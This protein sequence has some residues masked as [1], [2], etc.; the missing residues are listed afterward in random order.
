MNEAVVAEF[1]CSDDLSGVDSCI[2]SVPNGSNIDTAASGSHSFTVDSIDN[3]GNEASLTHFYD[4][5]S[6]AGAINE[7]VELV[8]TFNLQQGISNSLDA[9]LGNAREALEASNAGQRQDA[10]NKLE[11]FINAVEAQRSEKLTEAQA[12]QLIA[13]AQRIL[14][15]L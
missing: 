5:I 6:L 9:K 2:G 11:A 3:A 7:V 4:V 10:V 12:D 8:T 14:S 13:M 15:V 1:T